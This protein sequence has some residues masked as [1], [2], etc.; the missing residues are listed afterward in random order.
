MGNRIGLRENGQ[1][2]R[3]RHRLFSG[4]IYVTPKPTQYTSPVDVIRDVH[5]PPRFTGAWCSEMPT[6][7]CGNAI[8]AKRPV[9]SE[10][11]M[12]HTWSHGV[13]GI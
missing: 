4:A 7:L 8:F 6:R 11:G 5:S 9:V 2:T 13:S 3:A 10:V 12:A 1:S